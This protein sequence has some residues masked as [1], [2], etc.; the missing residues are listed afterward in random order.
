MKK[1]L[2]FAA[3]LMALMLVFVACKDPETPENPTDTTVESTPETPTEPGAD[4]TTEPGATDTTDPGTTDTTDP[5]TTETTDSETTD[6]ETET[7][8]PAP[9]EINPAD[10]T[11]IIDAEGLAAKAATGNSTAAELMDGFVRITSTGAD[12]FF[13]F[14]N[15]AGQQPQYLAISYRTNTALDGQIF[16]GSGAGP[17]G[18]GDNPMVSW[19]ED[20]NWNLAIIDLS[21]VASITDGNINYLRLDY[22]TDAGAEGDY[23]DI[24]FVAFF[25]TPEYAQAYAFELH[26]APMWDADKAVITHQSFD[27]LYKGMGDATAGEENLFTPGQ[28]ASWDKVA[29]LTAG[30]VDVLTYWGWVGMKGEIGQFGYQINGGSPIYNDEWTITAEQPV[31]DAAKP[32]GADNAS[33]MKIRI[34]LEGL[35]GENTVRTLYKTP[36]GVE[37]CLGE[38]KVI[39][40]EILPV[41]PEAPTETFVPETYAQPTI[42]EIKAGYTYDIGAGQFFQIITGACTYVDLTQ[43]NAGFQSFLQDVGFGQYAYYAQDHISIAPPMTGEKLIVTMK[44]YDLEGNLG[45]QNPEAFLLL[46]MQGGA[47]NSAAIAPSIEADPDVEGLYTLTFTEIVPGNTDELKFYMTQTCKFYIASVGIQIYIPREDPNFTN[48]NFDSDV[49]SNFANNQNDQDPK[50]SDLANLFEQIINGGGDPFLVKYNGG[51][52]YYHI[53]GFS[54][55]STRPVGNYAFTVNVVGTEGAE[56]FAGLFV[57]GYQKSAPEKQFYGGDG[58]DNGS[59][60]GGA[61]IYINHFR[62]GLDYVVRINIKTYADG[63][64]TP[65]IYYV[66]VDSFE[67]TVVDDGSVVT[68]LA[69]GKKVATVEIIG[70]KDYGIEGVPADALSEK[71]ILTLADGTVAE[72]DSAIV[73]TSVPE[74]DLGIGTRTGIFKFD[75]LSLKPADSV[76]IPADFYVPAEKVNVAQGKPVNADSVENDTNIASNATDGNEGTRWGATPR[77]VANMIVDLEAVYTLTEIMAYF[78]NASWKYEVSVSVDGEAYDVIH[79]GNPHGGIVVTIPVNADV[80]YIKFTRLD[81]TDTAGD[82]WFSIYEVYAFSVAAD[83][84]EPETPADPEVVVVDKTQASMVGESLDSVLVN[85]GFYFPDGQAYAKLAEVNNTVVVTAGDVVGFRGWI[86]FSQPIVALGCQVEGGEYYFDEFKTP[87]EDGVLA[88]GGQYATRYTVQIPT[89]GAEPGDYKVTWVALLENY[90]I[91]NIHTVTI[92]VQ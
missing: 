51:N 5:G 13:Q 50:Q 40:P 34:N 30:G 11:W 79:Q 45:A 85:G 29:D 76:E 17:N 55:L 74:S 21:G 73:A 19:N 44:V 3:I 56:G 4:D 86:G 12:P 15:A 28:S 6:T 27:Q 10:P 39:L 24:D 38:F 48:L 65:H 90:T 67:I 60:Y 58:N 82:H 54:G 8:P 75:R 41:V 7:D 77:G 20:G 52:P 53:A 26:K 64:F 25:N 81:D 14:L 42:D 62:R 89:D 46:N 61:G 57:R 63:K 22:F 87:T 31:I 23:F 80:R 9:P 92:T 72:L 36:D 2:I 84:D 35:G 18:Q 59:S 78:E 1:L 66:P 83:E 91:V 70:T 71:V 33:R 16:I 49:N 32:T 68:I 37:V 88:A 69:G 47:Q 43:L